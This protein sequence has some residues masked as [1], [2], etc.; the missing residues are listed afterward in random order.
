MKARDKVWP[1]TSLPTVIDR[2]DKKL[3]LACGCFDP[4]HAGHV[5]HL[6]EAKEMGD[7]LTVLV[8]GDMW[9]NKPGHPAF[10]ENMR[11]EVVA[12]LECVDYVAINTY[13]DAATAI[14][15]LQPDLYVKGADYKGRIDPAL[16]RER[17]ET[18]RNGGR[19]VFT[20]DEIRL[21]STEMLRRL[22]ECV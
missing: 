19:L 11:A 17:K 6:E 12:A 20:K 5:R 1:L 10:D 13:G 15:R 4:L 21:S 3:V 9:V 22:T 2:A 8:T 7:V 16:G 14:R 18:Q